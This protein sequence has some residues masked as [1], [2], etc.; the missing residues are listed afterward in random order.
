MSRKGKPSARRHL[1]TVCVWFFFTY[2]VCLILVSFAVRA[3]LL[4]PHPTR[5]PNGEIQIEQAGSSAN[6]LPAIIGPGV[7]LV[8][9]GATVLFLGRE[10]LSA[11]R[12]YREEKRL[13][14]IR[15][16]GT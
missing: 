7:G 16:S 2:L 5:G 12:A 14:L 11:V 1:V 6:K 15:P 10:V 8:A 3:Y 9:A 13:R 4:P